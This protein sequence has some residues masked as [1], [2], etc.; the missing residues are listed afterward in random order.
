MKKLID[1]TYPLVMPRKRFFLAF[2]LLTYLFGFA[3]LSAI[4]PEIFVRMDTLIVI[5]FGIGWINI[6]LLTRY[7][8][9]LYRK[10][11][12][13]YIRTYEFH[14]RLLLYNVQTAAFKILT[15]KFGLAKTKVEALV[16][17]PAADS[18]KV[19]LNIQE[20]TKCVE[21]MSKL[22][23]LYE[24][25]TVIFKKEEEDYKQFLENFSGRSQ[26]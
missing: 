7:E 12:T 8:W 21:E 3:L 23:V 20:F 17:D 10:G 4:D 6:M 14:K 5:L 24:L 19:E 16:N 11:R 18:K 13:G 22:N 26:K 2:L 1:L 9:R 15:A 25:E